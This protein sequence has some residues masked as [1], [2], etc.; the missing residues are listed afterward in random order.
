MPRPKKKEKTYVWVCAYEGC[1]NEF[2]T[3]NYMQR[4]CKPSHRQRQ[5]ELRRERALDVTV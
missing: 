5:Y 2:H 3:T 1:G 4:Y